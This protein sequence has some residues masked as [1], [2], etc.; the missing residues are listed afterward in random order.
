M[1][2]CC[3]ALL[4]EASCSGIIRTARNVVRDLGAEKCR[5]V[6]GLKALSKCSL[7]NPGRD[8]HKVL[9][10]K[11]GLSL[12]LPLTATRL[13]KMSKKK[14]SGLVHRLEMREW[15][16]YMMHVNSWH[17]LC[18]LLRPDFQRQE[19]IWTAF[20]EKYRAIDPRH[21]V[22]ELASQGKLML[23]RTCAVVLHGDEGRGRRRQAFMVLSWHS[24]LGRGTLASSAS[25]SFRR[26][27]KQYTKMKLNFRGH[28]YATRFVTGVLPRSLYEADEKTLES[29]LESVYED[30]RVM[31]TEGVD[32]HEGRRHWLMLLGTCGD[33]PFL[34]KCG[35]LDRSYANVA[36][37]VDQVS[38]GVC[39]LCDAGVQHMPW[40]EINTRRPSW[41][42]SLHAT[43]PFKSTPPAACVPHTPGQLANHFKYDVFHCWHLGVGRNYLGS[44]LA[45]L[46]G[47]ESGGNVDKRFENL[48]EKYKD[49]CKTTSHTPHVIR[50][51]KDLIQWTTTTDY[52]T[53]GWFKAGLTTVLMEFAKSFCGTVEDPLLETALAINDFFRL[54][55][56]CD[57][58]L[59]PRDAE[60]AGQLLSRFLRRYSQCATAAYQDR[61]ILFVLQPKLHALQHAAVDL[62]TGAKT[63]HDT[64]NP[65]S[66]SCQMSEDLVGRPSRLSRRVSARTT[67]KRVLQRYLQSCYTEWVKA[68]ILVESRR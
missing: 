18:G 60:L 28:T 46:S 49:W 35:R 66:V 16:K 9:V 20:W 19:A 56:A 62:L 24:M 39:H 57:V 41:I 2:V 48:T 1:L 31:A 67:V 68:G 44:V 3:Q 59:P 51:T 32:D 13:N 23:Q 45:M 8:A 58:W 55:Y 26:V 43:S 38:S 54:L 65:L 47:L 50:L 40:E 10:D 36:R 33:W 15:A 37:S 14:K 4:A 61:E 63:G 17:V 64:L 29:L 7:S 22:F 11:M 34:L 25:S 52:P 27:R 42:S 30:A 5:D 6:G 21:E 53:G 12:P